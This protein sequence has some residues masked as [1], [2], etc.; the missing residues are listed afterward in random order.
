MV[1]KRI[2][3]RHLDSSLTPKTRKKENP[4]KILSKI[5]QE[6][7]ENPGQETKKGNLGIHQNMVTNIIKLH[8]VVI[9]FNCLFKTEINPVKK[10][11]ISGAINIIS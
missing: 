8:P 1:T 2:T 5:S 9:Q 6:N 3:A 4:T 10:N 11:K 7:K